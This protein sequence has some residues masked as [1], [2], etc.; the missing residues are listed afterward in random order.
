[1]RSVILLLT[2]LLVGALATFSASNALRLR[3]AWPRG[4]MAVIQHHFAALQNAQRD[5]RCTADTLRPHL[6]MLAAISADIEPAHPDAAQTPDFRTQARRFADTT[7]RLA[8][9]PP[10]DCPAL[11]RE[12]SAL[13]DAC[14]A[15][16]RDY[17]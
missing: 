15:C 9:A 1:M 10:A 8:S 4:V 17:R 12:V 3:N 13:K 11:D 7:Q 5:K 16:H 6:D 2:G 14:N